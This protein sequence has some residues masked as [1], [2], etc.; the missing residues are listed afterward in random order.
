MTTP[1][2]TTTSTSRW[3]RV[4]TRLR[5]HD[6]AAGSAREPD[7]LA[8]AEAALPGLAGAPPRTASES[9]LA[10]GPSRTVPV[11]LPPATVD[12][13][14]AAR[15]A[16]VKRAVAEARGEVPA[17]PSPP[18]T[19][20]VGGPPG[21]L[22]PGIDAGSTD[23]GSVVAGSVVASSTDAGARPGAVVEAAAPLG[24]RD[25]R[26]IDDLFDDDPD[27]FLVPPSA[28]A[29]TAGTTAGTTG[30]TMGGSDPEPAGPAPDLTVTDAAVSIIAAM[31]AVQESHRR[32]LAAI[33]VET[34]RRCEMLTAQA[35][36]DAELLRL[37]ARR[38][39]HAIVSAAR[40]QADEVV[41]PV[42]AD[43]LSDIGESFSR[44][45]QAVEQSIATGPPP[46]DSAWP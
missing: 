2:D 31:R 34:E 27:D 20:D 36:L 16:R 12:A 46:P 41:S 17:H 33:E 26:A 43:Q 9:P 18:R 28:D 14:L 6:S 40:T 4:S 37:H 24:E 15:A 42:V 13:S 3:G 8:A 19:D 5:S 25:L 11:I 32:H 10:G 7:E 1:D 44:F 39:A 45:A 21:T 30:R 29:T 22:R 35:E 38:E 23:A